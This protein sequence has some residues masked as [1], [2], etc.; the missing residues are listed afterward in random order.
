MIT[1]THKAVMLMYKAYKFRLYP[2]DIQTELINKILGCSRY[3]YNHYL[4]K[5]INNGYTTSYNNIKDFT[6]TLRYEASFLQE[7]D[8]PSLKANTREI[9]IIPLPHTQEVP[10]I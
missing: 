10:A 9:A 3:T 2:N 1:L 8:I 7:I 6:N 5:M 4:D